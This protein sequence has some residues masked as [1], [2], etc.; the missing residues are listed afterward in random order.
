[1]T[2][3][4]AHSSLAPTEGTPESVEWSYTTDSRH[5]SRRRRHPVPRGILSH[6]PPVSHTTS[7]P[8]FA[9]QLISFSFTAVLTLFLVRALNPVGYGLLASRHCN[10]RR[11]IASGGLEPPAPSVVCLI[12]E[13]RDNH[14]TVGQVITSAL[15][16]KL[17][18]VGFVAVC[19]SSGLVSWRMCTTRR[20]SPGTCGRSRS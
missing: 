3:S 11:G 9:L 5:S 17:A 20:D 10:R 4:S 1:M 6:L 13:N 12:A 19:S 2:R 7:D 14:A 15:R 18:L 16:I 8:D